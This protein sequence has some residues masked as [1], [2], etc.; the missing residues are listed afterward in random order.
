MTRLSLFLVLLGSALLAQ[1]QVDVTFRYSAPSNPAIFVVGEFNSWTITAT[2]MDFQGNNLWT[3]TVRL[4]VGGYPNPPANGVP[5]AWQYKF[6]YAGASPWPNDPL[7]HNENSKDNSNTFIYTKDVTIY[8]FLP[9]QKQAIIK[10]NTPIIS[11][12]IFPKIGASVDTSSIK[13]T[14]N[15]IEYSNLGKYYDE[16]KKFLAFPAPVSLVN[17]K[18]FV[19][20]FVKASSGVSNVDSVNFIV[21][22]GFI[23]IT[24]Q[25]NFPTRNQ[26][27]LSAVRFKIQQSLLRKLFAILLIQCM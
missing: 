14:I 1:D 4:A 10:T 7:N 26:S 19:S 20:L 8:H 3:K 11:A 6:F 22:A 16:A 2:P 13:I 18:H 5:G 25:G 9:N 24:S 17:G 27:V 21:Q 15:G 12:Y 23:Q